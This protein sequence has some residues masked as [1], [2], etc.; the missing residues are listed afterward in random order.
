MSYKRWVSTASSFERRVLKGWVTATQY[1]T[2]VTFATRCRHCACNRSC[3]CQC[4]CGLAAASP[5]G[6]KA[7]GRNRF[8]LLSRTRRQVLQSRPQLP[9][10][11]R[12]V[13][14]Y[15]RSAHF[16]AALTNRLSQRHPGSLLLESCVHCAESFAL[17]ET[18]G[19]GP[20]VTGFCYC[21][22]PVLCPGA[23]CLSAAVAS[24]SLF[25]WSKIALFAWMHHGHL[26]MQG[27]VL[28]WHRSI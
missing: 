9:S 18:N 3:V 27:P 12:N 2:L 20:R 22:R 7:S 17:R 6:I 10:N 21:R 25:S 26:C 23:A 16:H 24:H 4:V 8:S 15:R 19:N 11:A 28:R 14:G 1:C 5:G 13:L